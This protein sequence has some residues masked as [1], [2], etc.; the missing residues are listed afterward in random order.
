MHHFLPPFS[1]RRVIML[2]MLALIVSSQ[3]FWL[4]RLIGWAAR[5][6]KGLA[7]RRGWAWAICL[8]YTAFLGMN[9]L[10]G[11]RGHSPTR[12]TAG[13]ALVEAPY[14][15]WIFGSTAGFLLFLAVKPLLYA[16]SGLAGLMNNAAA[17]QA[18][19]PDPPGDPKAEGG[20]LSPSR[21]QFLD[22]SATAISLAPFVAGAYG[23]FYGR[24]DLQITHYRT[25][26]ARLPRAFDGFRIVQL[27]DFHIGPFMSAREIRKYAEIANGLRGD[28]IAITGDFVTWDASTQGAAVDALSILKAPYGV[29]GCLGNH[30]IWT[31][32]QR[33]ITRLFAA[34]QFK[35]L[36]QQNHTLTAQGDSLNVIG[37]DFQSHRV[38]GRRVEGFVH[39]YLAGI[40]PLI[41]PHTANILL[42][43][44]PNTFDRAAELGIGLSLAGH[45][46]GGQVTLEFINP[47][48]SPARLMTPYVRGW[49]H[50]PGG[51]LYV[52]SGI[53]TIGVPMRID[54]PPEITVYELTTQPG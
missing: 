16:G 54:A 47:N 19:N 52:N 53:G 17:P 29:V 7:P 41:A 36:R 50:K 40:E 2:V 22:R 5:L 31:H 33:S 20:L 8:A 27:S 30:E 44:N 32:T 46:H 3:V 24:L 35:I 37:V 42:S 13:S 48:L 10:W 43:H 14:L 18:A 15:W 4:R 28:L 51:A 25:P 39:E 34:L 11:P 6:G 12:L 21:R 49:F 38:F 9:L 23:L 1:L 45:T 26:L